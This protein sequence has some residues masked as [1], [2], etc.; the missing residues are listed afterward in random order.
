MSRSSCKRGQEASVLR[1]IVGIKA[2]EMMTVRMLTYSHI[3]TDAMPIH[4]D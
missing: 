2:I 4:D 1:A 3:R